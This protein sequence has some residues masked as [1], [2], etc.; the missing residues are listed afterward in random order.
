MLSHTLSIALGGLLSVSEL[1]PLVTGGNANGILHFIFSKLTTSKKN[2]ILPDLENE[3]NENSNLNKTPHVN[4]NSTSDNE[5]IVEKITEKIIQEKHALKNELTEILENYNIEKSK[6][7]DELHVIKQDI[8]QDIKQNLQNTSKTSL[9]YMENVI[10]HLETK[11]ITHLQHNNN[12]NIVEKLDDINNII[13]DI[14]P[15][16]SEEMLEMILEYLQEVQRKSVQIAN[17]EEF[18]HNLYMDKLNIIIKESTLLT[19]KLHDTNKALNEQLEINN[20][21]TNK[22]IK[23]LKTFVDNEMSSMNEKI[24]LL[25]KKRNF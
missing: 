18:K 6:I 19:N 1:L 7:I 21:D 13:K 17:N 2:E 5:L 11:I 3:D 15:S 16:G 22:H 12:N 24:D 10:T 20:E 14:N 25:K 8:T 4:Y 23:E 9:E